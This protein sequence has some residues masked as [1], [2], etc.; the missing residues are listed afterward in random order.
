ML[1]VRPTVLIVDDSR[2][3]WLQVEY[4]LQGLDVELVMAS[5]GEEAV[6]QAQQHDFAL[7]LLDVVMGGMDGFQT[8]QLLRQQPRARYTPLIFLTGS[9]HD[10]IGKARGYAVGAIDYLLKPADPDMLRAKVQFFAEGWRQAE[11]LQRQ[12]AELGRL[13]QE[14]MAE[15]AQRRKAEAAL[16]ELNEELERRVHMRN[17]DLKSAYD[18]LRQS[19]QALVQ[20]E[21]LRALGQMA[22]GIAHDINNAISPIAIYAEALL[23]NEPNLTPR[24]RAYL[25]TIAQAIDDVA[26]TV[27][28]LRDF[29]RPQETHAPPE[30]VA[31]NRLVHQVLDLTRARWRDQP[32]Q[33]GITI[34]V[35]TELDANL[36][37]VLGAEVEMRD[38]LTN[39]VFNAIDAMPRGGTM[40]I[41]TGRTDETAHVYIDVADTGVGMDDDTRQRCLEPFF[42]TKGERGTGLGLAMVYGTVQRHGGAIRIQT[43]LGHGTCIRL[44][45]P[46]PLG[47]IEAAAS[48]AERREPSRSLRILVVDD[49]PLL[50]QSLQDTLQSDGHTV[51]AVDGGQAGIAAFCSARQGNTPFDLVITDLGMPYVDGRAVAQ[52]VKA[53]AA[54]PVLLL[55]G[56]GQ[57]L[58]S[59]VELPPHVDLVLAKPPKLKELRQALAALAREGDVHGRAP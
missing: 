17:Q 8:A 2:I 26:C 25:T 45:F 13:N 48:T 39:L 42:T 9:Y 54:T 1:S 33:R 53:Q 59:E 27:S 47:P 43:S 16:T 40:T 35:R 32:Q 56:W 37:A 55:T 31:V 51:V 34:D 46:L 23:D 58:R 49:D 15:T 14:L 18:E 28:R 29:Y 3:N 44:L 52:A 38:A 22:S 36:P 10:D 5:S 57:P 11:Q 41:R 30:P 20:Q 50:R 7:I 19:Q 24:A 4:A 12:A 6:R 21:R